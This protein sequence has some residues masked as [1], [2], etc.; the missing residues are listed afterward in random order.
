MN[1]PALLV[2]FALLPARAA[3]AE[4]REL[5]EVPRDLWGGVKEEVR[6][7]GLLTLLVA[8]SGASIA[9][10]SGA[11]HFDD[12]RIADSMRGHAYLGKRATDFGAVIGY[13]AYLIPVMGA[14]YFAGRYF[15]AGPTQEFGL[16]GFE[17]LVLAGVQTQ[18]LKMS[19]RRVRPDNTDRAAFPSG[20]TSASFALATVAASQWGWEVGVPACLLAGFVGYTRMEGRNHYFSDV[21]FG[22][23]VGIVSGRAVYK[24]RRR[25]HADRYV[26]APFIMPGGGGVAVSF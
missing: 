19:V 20:H 9:R 1:L 13:P 24:V 2:L 15:D 3:A 18:I 10:Y 17:A 21:L 26:F 6:P 4:L 16:A 14:T 5:R 8:G 23:G 7:E 25:A 22:A 12:Y 11:A